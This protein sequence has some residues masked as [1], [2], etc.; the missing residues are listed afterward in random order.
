MPR[1]C[2]NRVEKKENPFFNIAKQ[3]LNKG[4]QK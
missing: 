3:V 4:Q 2:D 1:K